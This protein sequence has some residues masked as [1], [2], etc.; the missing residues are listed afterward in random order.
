MLG[1]AID[2]CS[3]GHLPEEL[4]ANGY[5]HLIERNAPLSADAGSSRD[6][7]QIAA[8]FDDARV[9]TVVAKTPVIYTATMAGFHR[10][11]RDAEW[12]WRW[13]GGDGTWTIVNTGST[14]VVTTLHVEVSAFHRD[15]GLE[16]RLD[17]RPIQ[18]LRIQT[19][20]QLYDVGPLE[21]TPGEH[22]LVFH[23]IEDPTIAREV[24]DT[25]D[26]RRLSFAIGAWHWSIGG[27]QP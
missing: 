20:R 18:S 26:S 15:R 1:G 16:V 6:G 23:P 21:V 9:F 27:S 3:D 25:T 19:P 7:L 11:E 12:A 13:M 5:T 2:D 8:R 17:G 4:A 22:Q 10:R 14:A 24:I